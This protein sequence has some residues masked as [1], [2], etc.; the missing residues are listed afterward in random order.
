MGEEIARARFSG[1]DFRRFAGKLEAET[2]ELARWFDE[3]RF[4]ESP[5]RAGF[6]LEAWLTDR[7]FAPAPLNGPF[8]EALGDPLV[9]PELAKFN[10]ELNGPPLNLAGDAFSDLHG[11]LAGLWNR[12]R[13]AAA[14]LEAGML[15]IGTHPLAAEDSLTLENMTPHHRYR[16]LNEQIM[17]LRRGQ[18]LA[19]S[20]PEGDGLHVAHRDLT[21]ESAATSFQIHLQVPPARAARFFNASLV[22]SGPMVAAAANS[23]FL[24]GRAL[25]DETRIPLFEQSVSVEP[26]RVTFGKDYIRFSL[27]ECFEENLTSHSVLLP[28]DLGEDTAALR[29]LCLHNGT[30]WRWN[31]PLVGF[32][33]NGTPHLRIEHRTVPAGPSIA[34]SVANSALY[35][36]LVVELGSRESPPELSLPFARARENFYRAAREGLRARMRWRG[37]KTCSAR[38]LILDELLPCARRGLERL[39]ISGADIAAYLAVIEERV[40]SGRNGAEWQRRAYLRR[41]DFRELVAAY[42]RNQ[43]RDAPVHTW[44]P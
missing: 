24:F 23:P 14:G 37:G 41:K 34:D 17:R 16:A 22:V 40:R 7:D 20:I 36:G 29:H 21:F 5:P 2:A 1:R 3:S 19:L 6:E 42:H 4:E 35:C 33:E 38:E 11:A 10:V 26:R 44:E 32:H 30:I 13:T 28:E 8:L 9:V 39:G 12:C 15:M 18:P 27:L 43:E 25:W 31:R